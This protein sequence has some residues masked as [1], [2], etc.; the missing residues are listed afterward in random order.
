M[1]HWE[2]IICPHCGSNSTVEHLRKLKLLEVHAVRKGFD[3]LEA[4]QIEREY[5][6]D[7]CE[8]PFYGTLLRIA[9]EDLDDGMFYHAQTG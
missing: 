6:C 1:T 4:R 5:Y 2:V 9:T 7:R 3:Q 8:K